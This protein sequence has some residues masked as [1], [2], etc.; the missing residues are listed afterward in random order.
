M[1]QAIELA[2]ASGGV[3]EGRAE[4]IAQ[5]VEKGRASGSPTKSVD[6]SAIAEIGNRTDLEFFRDVRPRRTESGGGPERPMLLEGVLVGSLIEIRLRRNDDQ[7]IS[8]GTCKR[9]HR[10]AVLHIEVL[11]DVDGE[12][13]VI[14]ATIGQE[15]I[16]CGDRLA[17]DDVVVYH[18]VQRSEVRLVA[19]DPIDDARAGRE[20]LIPRLRAVLA[21][22]DTHT[23]VADTDVEDAV[24]L[25]PLDQ[26]SDRGQRIRE[27]G[28]HISIMRRG[29]VAWSGTRS[30]V[31]IGAVDRKRR[32]G[33]P[34]EAPSCHGVADP[35]DEAVPVRLEV[36]PEHNAAG[37][38]E[39]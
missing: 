2:G 26:T 29:T 37:A 10:L 8:D 22:E 30:R 7:N 11:D 31:A 27:S 36:V 18:F 23:P 16:Q 13:Q 20:P 6:Q 34:L 25:K 32:A 1:R 4:A 38:H 12:R 5:A 9:E 24:R 19:L 33:Q 39:A 17:D 14:P 28:W 3:A 35:R 15:G 21:S